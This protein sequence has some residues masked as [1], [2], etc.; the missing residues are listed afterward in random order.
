MRIGHFFFRFSVC[1][2]LILF[3]FCLLANFEITNSKLNFCLQR[4]NLKRFLCKLYMFNLKFLCLCDYGN[5]DVFS[6]LF[7]L[8]TVQLVL[9]SDGTASFREDCTAL[10]EK[11]DKKK[12]GFGS[13]FVSMVPDPASILNKYSDP[14]F[15][16][17]LSEFF[18]SFITIFEL[19]KNCGFEE[20][21]L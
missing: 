3:V 12:Q 18:F 9:A 11:Q 14:T 5:Y 10:A 15:F 20:T 6:Y 19:L 1:V 8:N 21:V 17:S 16:P 7:Q 13:V 2:G 4:I